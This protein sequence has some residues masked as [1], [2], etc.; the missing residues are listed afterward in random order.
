MFILHPSP[1]PHSYTRQKKQGLLHSLP[2]PILCRYVRRRVGT[3]NQLSDHQNKM[4][5]SRLVFICLTSYFI[6]PKHFRQLEI[7]FPY[8]PALP[9]PIHAYP[10]FTSTCRKARKGKEGDINSKNICADDILSKTM[11]SM[12]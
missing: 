12:M 3:D 11:C 8:S 5:T 10:F 1:S 9:F 7:K 2:Q 6:P 4:R